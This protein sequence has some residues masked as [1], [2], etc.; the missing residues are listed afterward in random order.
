MWTGW[1]RWP[2]FSRICA[3][4]SAPGSSR[5]SFRS[6]WLSSTWAAGIFGFLQLF[7]FAF[8]LGPFLVVGPVAGLAFQDPSQ[9]PNRHRGHWLE[10]NALRLGL[11]H[12]LCAIL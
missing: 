1:S 8:V 2:A 6:A 10:E 12:G 5:R 4:V 3:T 11:N 7:F 9:T